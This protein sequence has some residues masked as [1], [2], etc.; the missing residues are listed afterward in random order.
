MRRNLRG[1]AAIIM[2]YFFFLFCECHFVLTDCWA[3]QKAR[4]VSVQPSAA[5]VSVF[6]RLHA[7][8]IWLAGTLEG[9]MLKGLFKGCYSTQTWTFVVQVF[10]KSGKLSVIIINNISLVLNYYYSYSV[11]VGE[12]HSSNLCRVV[13]GRWG[14]VVCCICICIVQ[15]KENMFV[16]NDKRESINTGIKKFYCRYSTFLP[17]SLLSSE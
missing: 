13:Q 6:Q 16:I 11:L 9:S 12:F 5:L 3:V 10:Q 15:L 14:H 2:Q 4:S 17:P 8:L 1:A 7:G